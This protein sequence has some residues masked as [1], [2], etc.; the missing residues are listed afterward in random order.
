VILTTTTII[1]S[2]GVR[3][4]K[5]GCL[6]TQKTLT[7]VIDYPHRFSLFAIFLKKPKFGV[8]AK[9][10]LNP[11]NPAGIKPSLANPGFSVL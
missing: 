1:R 2:C 4:V 7:E 3:K 6:S 9:S 5:I 11:K 10:G 8:W